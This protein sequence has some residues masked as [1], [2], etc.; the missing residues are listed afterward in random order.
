MIAFGNKSNSGSYNTAY[1]TIVGKKTGQGVDPNWST[2]EIHIDTA[3]VRN[4]SNARTAY[5]DNDPAFKIDGN[6][7]I[8]MPYRSYAYGQWTPGSFGVTNGTGFQMSVLRSQNMTYA[9]NASHGYG[10]T[11]VKPGLYIMHATGLYDPG[12]TY[13]YVG[14]CVNGTQ[15]HHWHS[16]Q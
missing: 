10:M 9:N 5:M 3:G 12:G 16:N 2:G 11:V 14:W 15:I 13:I 8:T 1:A 6:G 7:D 4:G